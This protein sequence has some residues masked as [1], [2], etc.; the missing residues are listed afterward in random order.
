MS[1]DQLFHNR[2]QEAA[3]RY[4]ALCRQVEAALA[5]GKR[6]RLRWTDWEGLDREGW[7]RAFLKVL[8]RRINLK[9]GPLP[10]WRKLDEAYQVGLRRDQQRL[11]A[12]LQQRVRCYQ[13][14]TD[15]A[16]QRFGHLLPKRDD[17]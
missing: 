13:F 17:E 2:H 8:D 15:F 16:R 3:R 4:L 12:W 10:R 14:E 6:V 11:H 7:R 5:E 1:A 9:A